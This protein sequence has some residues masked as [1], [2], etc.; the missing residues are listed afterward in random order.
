MKSVFAKGWR[1]TLVLLLLFIS[2]EFIVRKWDI[3]DWLLPAPSTVFREAVTGWMDFSVH[4]VS[5][6]NL[7]LSGFLIG[8][9]IGLFSAILLYLIPLLKDSVYPLLILSQNIP[10][11]VLAPL[12]VIWFGF[13]TL[14]QNHCYYFSLLTFQ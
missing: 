1:S 11:I 3:P 10:T 7:S 6:I 2:W 4:L 12:L 14:P 5:T 8:T 9:T 13:G